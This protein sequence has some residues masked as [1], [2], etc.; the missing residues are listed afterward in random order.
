MRIIGAFVVAA[1]DGVSDS[2]DHRF[3]V[4]NLWTPSTRGD[5][6][7]R[8]FATDCRQYQRRQARLSIETSLRRCVG[9]EEVGSL[10]TFA[11]D[12]RGNALLFQ[13]QVASQF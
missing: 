4:Y 9:E 13:A 12:N 6:Q 2:D 8:R 7:F 5:R 1:Q 11:S 3:D 10:F